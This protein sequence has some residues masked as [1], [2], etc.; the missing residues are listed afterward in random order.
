MAYTADEFK[1]GERVKFVPLVKRREAR[2]GWVQPADH[3]ISPFVTVLL[4]GNDEVGAY[5]CR[6][7]RKVHP[8]IG[9]AS[10]AP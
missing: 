5:N 7:L 9:L 4:D 10:V 8:L 6:C 3:N 1:P 2:L